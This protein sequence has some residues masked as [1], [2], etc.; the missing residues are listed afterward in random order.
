MFRSFG[1]STRAVQ[2]A[3]LAVTL[4]AVILFATQ[5]T[6]APQPE[7]RRTTTLE[8]TATVLE[9]EDLTPSTPAASSTQD[10]GAGAKRE[11]ASDETAPATEQ[12]ANNPQLS[13]A[14]PTVTPPVDSAESMRGT[15]NG[16]LRSDNLLQMSLI[17]CQPNRFRMGSPLDE[18]KRRANEGPVD[19][20]LTRG[21]WLGQYEVT[22]QQWQAVMGTQP[23]AFAA[24]GKGWDRVRDMDTSRLPVESIS[25]DE[26]VEFCRRLTEAERKAGRLADHWAYCLPTEAQWENACRAGSNTATAHGDNIGSH[27][28]NFNGYEPYNGADYGASIGRTV[29]VGSYE[30]N[31]WGFYDIQGNVWE[32]CRN[33]YSDPPLGGTDPA[34]PASGVLRV[35]RGGSWWGGGW[36]ARCSFRYWFPP[37][38]A[39]WGVGFRVCLCLQEAVAE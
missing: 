39:D 29:T 18:P 4:V 2:V 33:W 27:Q 23:S 14:P 19:V 13:E 28:A 11:A 30:P 22:Q 36:N 8:T 34:G 32:H 3:L 9:T 12:V 17:W 15:A 24:T 21:Y 31:N 20:E 6:D 37:E 25:H 38:K 35:A 10:R 16:Q 26:A 7:P 5:L 1:H